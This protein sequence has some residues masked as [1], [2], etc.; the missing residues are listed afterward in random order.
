VTS[1]RRARADDNSDLAT[2][3]PVGPDR[4]VE[5]QVGRELRTAI[6]DGSLPPGVRLPYRD[7]A[8]RFN[9]SVTPVRVAV[10][11]LAY[12]GLVEVN[13]H[14]GARVA[15]LSVDELE[16]LFAMR[17][18]VDS[19]LARLGSELISADALASMEA[20]LNE[21]QRVV[22]AGD[23]QPYLQLAWSVRRICYQAAER[24]RL[25]QVSTSLF[26][27]S[28]RYNSFTLTADF[29]VDESFRHLRDLHAACRAHDGQA[30]QA[31]TMAALESTFA[32][33]RAHF[34]EMEVGDAV[35][36]P[37]RS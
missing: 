21:A 1:N 11:E 4:T 23:G 14:G 17:I 5:R 27:R 18:G 3:K 9:V 2:V 31:T 15:P 12:E 26:N 6:L 28:A 10:L 16:E 29:R 37:V 30:A 33:L 25:L 24:P 22:D 35:L 13:A 20:Q 19:W 32:Y 8:R 34:S 7:L 36:R